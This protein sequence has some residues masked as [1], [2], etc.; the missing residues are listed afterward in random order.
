M[1]IDIYAAG[2]AYRITD[3]APGMRVPELHTF[4][5]LFA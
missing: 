2:V 3:S 4:D 5:T 1:M